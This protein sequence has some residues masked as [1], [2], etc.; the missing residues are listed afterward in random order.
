MVAQI[1]R[2]IKGLNIW[3]HNAIKRAIRPIRIAI[4]IAGPVDDFS[5]AVLSGSLIRIPLLTAV[6]LW[7][8]PCKD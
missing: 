6:H 8:G 4:S 7:V 5:W 2:E 1:T 3:K